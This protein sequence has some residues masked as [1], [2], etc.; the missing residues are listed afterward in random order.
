LPLA[1]F[2]GVRVIALNDTGS[3]TSLKLRWINQNPFKSV[4]FA[5]LQ[6][7][8]ELATGILL[9]QYMSEKTPFS[10]LLTSTISEYHKKA[11]GHIYFK[12]EQGLE[13]KTFVTNMLKQNDGM[14]IDIPVNAYNAD[15]ELIAA[16]SFNWSC[17][18]RAGK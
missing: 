17:K 6:M 12:C 1:F 5:A 16:F 7:A 13:V 15:N 18:K 9:Y 11:V 3:T 2:A 4:Y 14:S 10:M 8:A